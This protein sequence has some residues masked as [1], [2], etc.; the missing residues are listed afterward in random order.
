MGT[1]TL[2]N[3]RTP[4]GSSQ[5]VDGGKKVSSRDKSDKTKRSS[6]HLLKDD[7]D[8]KSSKKDKDK[9]GKSTKSHDTRDDSEERS[10]KQK[11]SS[12]RGN[13]QRNLLKEGIEKKIGKTR[14]RLEEQESKK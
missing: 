2:S 11:K 7:H 13:S 10:L 9:K 1:R 4:R 6:R 5:Q 12:S 14:S 8:R 3:R